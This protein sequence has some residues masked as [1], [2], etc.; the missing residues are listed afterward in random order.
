MVRTS[1]RKYVLDFLGI[2]G[3]AGSWEFFKGTEERSNF[4]TE[5]KGGQKKGLGEGWDGSLY[6]NWIVEVGL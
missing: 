2:K 4:Y 1:G 6:K 5:V 3:G